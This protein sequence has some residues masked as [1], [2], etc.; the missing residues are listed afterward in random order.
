MNAL[1]IGVALLVPALAHADCPVDKSL[2]VTVSCS[3][4][5]IGGDG[6]KVNY[7]EK[8]QRA[9]LE[10]GGASKLLTVKF[11]DYTLM[12][13]LSCSGKSNTTMDWGLR[14]QLNQ[15]KVAAPL[16]YM[17]LPLPDAASRKGKAPLAVTSYEY[18]TPA[19]PNPNKKNGKLTRVDYTCELRVD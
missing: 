2:N 19:V 18:L 11:G 12:G 17:H 1:V 15:K 9:P 3:A 10:L 5:L 6:S 4:E 16:A 7:S 8:T 14:V 13:E